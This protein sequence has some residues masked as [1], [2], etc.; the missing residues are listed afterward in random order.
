MGLFTPKSITKT[1]LEYGTS[2]LLED[3]TTIKSEPM[4][5]CTTELI[6]NEHAEYLYN[7][8]WNSDSSYL[9]MA[10]SETG[11]DKYEIT[12]EFRIKEDQVT[13]RLNWNN[14]KLCRYESGACKTFTSYKEALVFFDGVKKV[15]DHHFSKEGIANR[16]NW[17][18]QDCCCCKC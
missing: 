9:K 11:Y 14:T 13:L 16:N 17:F 12:P 2:T 15:Y 6:N 18:K 7:P 10:H 1:N 3:T 4:C 8:S 5:T